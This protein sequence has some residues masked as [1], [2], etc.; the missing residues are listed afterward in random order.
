MPRAPGASSPSAR[1]ACAR[2]SRRPPS[3]ELEGRT[4]LFINRPYD[5][6]VVDVMMTNFHLPRTTLLMMIDAFVGDRW[7]RLYDVALAERLPLP[8][9]RRRDAARPAGRSRCT[10]C[11]SRRWRR[12]GVGAQRRR[13]HRPRQLPHAVLHAGRNPRRDQVPQRRRLRAARRRDRAR[14]HVPPDAATGCRDGRRAR[15]PRHAS[16]DGTG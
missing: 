10:R 12:D 4:R 1:R 3:G 5:W 11:A 9:L 8:Q 2:S 14:Q 16:P 13:P 7:R 6:Q 15:R